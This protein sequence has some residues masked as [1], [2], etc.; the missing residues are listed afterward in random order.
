MADRRQRNAFWRL[1][2]LPLWRDWLAWL[3]VVVVFAAALVTGRMYLDAGGN[4]FRRGT[5][6]NGSRSSSTS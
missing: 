6:E 3:T 5:G 4:S 2:D 1:Y